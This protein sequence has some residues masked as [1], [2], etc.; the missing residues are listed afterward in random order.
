[1]TTW[2]NPCRFSSSKFQTMSGVPPT[3]GDTDHDGV[4][5][6]DEAIMGTDPNSATDV[7]RLTQNPALPTQ[8][9]FPSKAGRFYR[10]Y[11]SDDTDGQEATHLLKWKDAG[12]TTIVGNGG[13]KQFNVTV[14]P[15]EKRRFYRLHVMATD[16]PWPATDRL[17]PAGRGTRLRCARAPHRWG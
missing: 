14:L 3:G 4:S 1:M 11:A 16:G 15:A 17:R 9:S 2:R 10:V 12:L 8:I 6:A 13:P 5:D 7:L